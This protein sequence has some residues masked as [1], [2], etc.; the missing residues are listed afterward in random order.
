MAIIIK[1]VPQEFQP[2]YN[3]IVFV[4]DST[5]KSQPKFQYV[6][7]ISVGGL[8]VS[9]IKVQ[10]NPQGYGVFNISKHLES[11]VGSDIDIDNLDIF[12]DIENTY[13][14]YTIQGFEEYEATT[15][16]ARKTITT[17]KTTSNALYRISIIKLIGIS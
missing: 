5:N 14:G 1:V 2:T 7:D 6:I 15:T 11:Y 10:S 13:G 9:R 16:T 4:L 3:E 8:Y 17:T 12:K